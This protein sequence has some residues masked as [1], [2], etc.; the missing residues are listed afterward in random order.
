MHGT[1]HLVV[2][3]DLIAEGQTDQDA[4]CGE[5]T[6]AQPPAPSELPLLQTH[7]APARRRQVLPTVQPMAPPAQQQ[8][9]GPAPGG[10]WA[11]GPPGAQPAVV[12]QMYLYIWW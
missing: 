8:A 2:Q 3:D 10:C 7:P 11:P 6:A 9:P 4:H 1:T 5:Q 12:N